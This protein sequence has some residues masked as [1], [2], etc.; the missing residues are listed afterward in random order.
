MNGA[1]LILFSMM[2]TAGLVYFLFIA[3][4]LMQNPT[5]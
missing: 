1:H 4:C 5:G 3:L 2:I